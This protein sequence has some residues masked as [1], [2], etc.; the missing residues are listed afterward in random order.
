MSDAIDWGALK[1]A[2]ERA[3]AA[4]YA[5]YSNFQVGAALL[6]RDGR[7]FSGCN[8]ENASF[9]LTVCAERNAMFAAVAGGARQFAALVV[10]S[11]ADTPVTPCGACR[12]VLLEFPPEY[13]VRCYGRAG[14]ELTLRS[15]ELL[16]HAFASGDFQGPSST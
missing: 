4:A 16:P 6:S 3:A 1:T 7:V 12:Q 5:P 2:A 15:S 14:Q 9:G 8:V 13:L 11:S 10:V